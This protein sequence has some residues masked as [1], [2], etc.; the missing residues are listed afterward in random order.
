MSGKKSPPLPATKTTLQIFSYTGVAPTLT[1]DMSLYWTRALLPEAM[2]LCLK[3]AQA[4]V[5]VNIHIC[6]LPSKVPSKYRSTCTFREKYE[7]S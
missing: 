6:T 1:S 2:L 4:F 7:I 3:E 5:Y